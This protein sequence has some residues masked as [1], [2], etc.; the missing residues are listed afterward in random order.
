MAGGDATRWADYRGTPKH[1]IEVDGEPILHRTVRLL[2][3]RVDTVWVVSQNNSA[4]HQH[5]A[6]IYT[7]TPAESDADKFYSSRDLWSGH[8]LLVYGEPAG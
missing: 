8:T 6:N 4:Y 5:G 3:Q 7:I 2:K 1:L